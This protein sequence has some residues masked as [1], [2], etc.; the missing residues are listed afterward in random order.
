MGAVFLFLNLGSWYA[1]YKF[2]KFVLMKIKLFIF[3]WL[4]QI[5]VSAQKVA[6]QKKSSG[7]KLH[8]N[9]KKSMKVKL[10]DGKKYQGNFRIINDSLIVSE[11]DSVLLSDV[12][13]FKVFKRDQK[14]YG[15][16]WLIFG[17]S[18]TVFNAVKFHNNT[19]WD[20][21][22]KNGAG[23]IVGTYISISALILLTKRKKITPEKW[24]LIIDSNLS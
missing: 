1:F 20:S 5:N 8:I 22:Y 21:L 13:Y 10:R 9:Y 7:K 23:I 3:L 12:Q 2:Q 17:G 14:S 19:G 15:S 18:L 11:N 24:I 4:I 16:F 6:F